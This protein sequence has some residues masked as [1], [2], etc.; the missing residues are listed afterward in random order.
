MPMTYAAAHAD[1]L[2]LEL[3]PLIEDYLGRDAP[4]WKRTIA[5][6]AE[7]RVEGL[8]A[9]IANTEDA[10]E[11]EE[12][13]IEARAAVQGLRSWFVAV[14]PDPAKVRA[15]D[16]RFARSWGLSPEDAEEF[17]ALLEAERNG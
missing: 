3:Q 12:L 4:E 8:L 5:R 15:A 7:R 1:A 17:A 10:G 16:A 11:R 2:R 9:S 14:A 6:D 13:A